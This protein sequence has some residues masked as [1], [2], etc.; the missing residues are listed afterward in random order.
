MNLRR[1]SS[2]GSSGGGI[3]AYEC[4]FF[5]SILNLKINS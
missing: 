5:S 4:I 3:T 2:G 1:R